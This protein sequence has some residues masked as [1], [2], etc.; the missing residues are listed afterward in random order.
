MPKQAVYLRREAQAIKWLR[1]QLGVNLREQVELS[2]SK[3]QNYRFD[4]VSEDGKIVVEVR[5]NDVPK[6]GRIRDTQLAE[7]SEACLFMLGV[8]NAERRILAF[9]QKEFYE[10]F[11]KKRQACL[12]ESLGIEVVPTR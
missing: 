11:M 12:Y 3:T 6:R 4:G 9:T 2:V 5:S 1:K 10:P 7:A 8:K